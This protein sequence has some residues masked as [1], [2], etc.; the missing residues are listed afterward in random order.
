MLVVVTPDEYIVQKD[1]ELFKLE[2][3]NH[4]SLAEP[5]Y[6]DI[7]KLLLYLNAGNCAISDSDQL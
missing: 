3:P 6:V 7:F 5:L 2:E 1:S 4:Q